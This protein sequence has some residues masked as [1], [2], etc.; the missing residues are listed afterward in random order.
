[1]LFGKRYPVDA[2]SAIRAC[3]S[4]NQVQF[5]RGVTF[6]IKGDDMHSGWNVQSMYCVV[7]SVVLVTATTCVFFGLL[8]MKQSIPMM[9]PL[10]FAFDV[11]T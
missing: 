9:I 4:G 11:F 2:S 7:G 8:S 6:L 5:Q 3:C 1:M 10:A